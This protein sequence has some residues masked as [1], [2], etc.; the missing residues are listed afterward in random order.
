MDT[1]QEKQK[2][3]QWIK[4]KEK[5]ISIAE[6]KSSDLAIC[7]RIIAL[8]AYHNAN[9]VFCFVGT[10][11][12]INTVPILEQVWKDGKRLA[13]PR[14]AQKGIMY[15]YEI[16]S[17][18][19]LEE[20]QY[21]ILEPK[22]KCHFVQSNEID[23]AVIPCVSCDKEGYRLGHGGGYY[24]RYLAHITFET[25]VVCREKLLL[26]HTPIDEFD[27]R[28]DWVITENESIRI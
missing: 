2:W 14:C 7:K 11:T 3:R 16:L 28:M 8:E 26:N 15:A 25:A 17:M 21:G 27:C 1:K 20:G 10:S 18:D 12:E 23:F 13:V 24:D 19:D 6:K 5:E 22:T 9:T 4:E